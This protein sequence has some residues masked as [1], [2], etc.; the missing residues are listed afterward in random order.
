MRLHCVFFWVKRKI[1]LDVVGAPENLNIEKQL[2][3]PLLQVKM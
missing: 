2:L 3:V 1:Y